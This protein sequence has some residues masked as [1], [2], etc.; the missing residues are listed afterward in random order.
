VPLKSQNALHVAPQPDRLVDETS[1][2]RFDRVAFARRALDLLR[3]ARTTVAICE[4]NAA[5]SRTRIEFGPIWG[6][7][8]AERWAMLAIAPR[9]S[10]RAIALAIAELT[11]IPRRYGLDVLMAESAGLSLATLDSD[12]APA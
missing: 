5:S 2:E 11:G 6:R 10:R 8:P 12:G 7:R 1:E 3:P 9:A 4:G